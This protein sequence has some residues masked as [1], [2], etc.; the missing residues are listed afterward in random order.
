MPFVTT[1]MHF[2][3]MMLSE[4]RQREKDKYH[5]ILLTH[6]S[7]PPGKSHTWIKKKIQNTLVNRIK[8]KQ[9]HRYRDQISRYQRERGLGG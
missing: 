8:L 3:G 2:E 6:V 1:W 5:M 4:I 7:E 9:I